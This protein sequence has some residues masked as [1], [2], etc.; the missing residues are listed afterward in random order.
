MFL[1][2]NINIG[3]MR[4]MLFFLLP[5]YLLFFYGVD[6]SIFSSL[7]AFSGKSISLVSV[8]IFSLFYTFMV[9]LLLKF[10]PLMVLYRKQVEQIANDRGLHCT[11]VYQKVV[12]KTYL[13][14]TQSLCRG[15]L[16]FSSYFKG[17][18]FIVLDEQNLKEFGKLR[19]A[20]LFADEVS[21]IINFRFLKIRQ[22]SMAFV[23]L[24][25][26]PFFCLEFLMPKVIF[27]FSIPL[28]SAPIFLFYMLLHKF[29]PLINIKR[30][31]EDSFIMIRQFVVLRESDTFSM[32]DYSLLEV[33]LEGITIFPKKA[34]SQIRLHYLKVLL[35]E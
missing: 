33:L 20:R 32:G 7:Y 35:N 24:Y 18:L 5:L 30:L 9:F 14:L 27:R 21:S 31:D 28:I 10:G 22:V 8:G 26:L 2:C 15:G 3:G 19:S 34:A 4:Y 1:T 16:V 11:T 17:E 29:F 23:A 25:L 12:G 13:Y 6:L